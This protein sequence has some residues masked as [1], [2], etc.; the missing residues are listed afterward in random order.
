MIPKI[1]HY[2]WFGKK[3]KPE[4][5][6]ELI[7]SWKKILPDYQIIEWNENNCDISISP[8][9]VK[10]AYELKKWAFVSDYFRLKAL[11]EFGGIYLD[12]DVEIIKKFD[13]L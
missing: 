8:E 11:Y 4:K 10:T 1:I 3:T 12:T 7:L 6:E 2:C 9:Y 5:I 13:D